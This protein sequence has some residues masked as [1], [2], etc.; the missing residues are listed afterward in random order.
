MRTTLRKTKALTYVSSS[1]TF[2]STL[3]PKGT[4]DVR[5][6]WIVA[7]V[8]NGL[9]ARLCFASFVSLVNTLCAVCVAAKAA[10]HRISA[11]GHHPLSGCHPRARRPRVHGQVEWHKQQSTLSIRPSV[12]KPQCSVHILHIH[13][14]C[15]QLLVYW[16]SQFNPC[17]CWVELHRG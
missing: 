6:S 8:Y 13:K 11:V 16:N 12:R 1:K 5:F 9:D 17:M 14:A 3:S 4:T 2:P 15:M 7:F 10:S